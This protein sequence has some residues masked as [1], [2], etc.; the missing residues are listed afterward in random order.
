VKF[1]MRTS[2]FLMYILLNRC[3]CTISL[4]SLIPAF[5]WTHYHKGPVLC[6]FEVFSQTGQPILGAATLDPK[7]FV[8]TNNNNNNNKTSALK[9]RSISFLL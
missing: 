5:Y 8:L 6:V 7:S 3:K 4:Y 9:K 2:E 1:E